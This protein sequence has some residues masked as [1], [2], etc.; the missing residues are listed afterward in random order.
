MVELFLA[1]ERIAQMTLLATDIAISQKN[2]PLAEK[3]LAESKS[4]LEGWSKSE[5]GE[6][7][8][9][10]QRLQPHF[11]EIQAKLKAASFNP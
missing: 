2:F 1:R 11:E 6:D 3:Y 4:I 8:E 9:D 7:R 10:A 5:R